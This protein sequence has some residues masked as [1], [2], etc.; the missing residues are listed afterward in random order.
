[1]T[2]EGEQE[3]ILDY[4]YTY[5]KTS[6]K[7]WNVFIKIMPTPTELIKIREGAQKQVQR[8]AEE[9]MVKQEESINQ[10]QQALENGQII[11]E[12]AKL[13]IKR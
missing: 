12:R 5:Y 10:I 7:F 1:L 4:Y 8:M 6:E 3:D 2:V 9:L 13:E 11:D